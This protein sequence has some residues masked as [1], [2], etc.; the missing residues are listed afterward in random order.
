VGDVLARE[1]DWR[2]ERLAEEL[3]RFEQEAAAE[4]ILADTDR[5]VDVVHAG[6]A[7]PTPTPMP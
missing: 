2:P 7:T 6:S 5:P 4:G 1:L 3:R